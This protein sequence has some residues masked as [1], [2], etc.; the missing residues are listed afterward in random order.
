MGNVS[1]V[2]VHTTVILASQETGCELT[3]SPRCR[4]RG[5]KRKSNRCSWVQLDSTSVVWDSFIQLTQVRGQ[6]ATGSSLKTLILES[7]MLTT[8]VVSVS[9]LD[10]CY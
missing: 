8:K 7:S 4:E 1:W 9:M 10:S 6:M 3:A 5:F 2:W